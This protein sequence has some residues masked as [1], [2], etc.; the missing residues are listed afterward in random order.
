MNSGLVLKHTATPP[1]LSRSQSNWN[2]GEDRRTDRGKK[3]KKLSQSSLRNR[4]QHESSTV[5]H[6]IRL[7]IDRGGRAYQCCTQKPLALG[8]CTRPRQTRQNY[9]PTNRQI[10]F[11]HL[12]RQHQRR[13]P[14][15]TRSEKISGIFSDRLQ[16]NV[17]CSFLCPVTMRSI[18]IDTGNTE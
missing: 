18:S 4:F 3:G 6:R 7:D 9:P 8:V 2:D 13:F 16:V 14:V 11:S 5:S 15:F 1:L 10:V 12:S 17:I